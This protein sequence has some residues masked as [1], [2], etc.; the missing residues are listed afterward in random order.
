MRQKPIRFAVLG[1]LALGVIAVASFIVT[2]F[3]YLA[4]LDRYVSAED[5]RHLN[6]YA[7]MGSEDTVLLH[8]VRASDDGVQIF[9][10]ARRPPRRVNDLVGKSFGIGIE[11][12]APLG[13]RRVTD[14]L[15][16]VI[17]ETQTHSHSAVHAAPR[18]SPAYTR[19][20]TR[21]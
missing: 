16:R 6:V 17:H 12:D 19:D 1:V 8:V 5:R 10:W 11:L 14:Y 18:P 21:T 7:L 20:K 3:T 13:D 15:G 2:T 4:P 9:V